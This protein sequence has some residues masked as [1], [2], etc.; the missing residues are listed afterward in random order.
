M[1]YKQV[2]EYQG[3]GSKRSQQLS[4]T[5]ELHH[6]YEKQV[7]QHEN[8]SGRHSDAEKA[9]GI[10]GHPEIGLLKLQYAG[11]RNGKH[12]QEG[13]WQER[14]TEIISDEEKVKGQCPETEKCHACREENQGLEQHCPETQPLLRTD[15]VIPLVVIMQHIEYD[16][17]GEEGGER[18]VET[19]DGIVLRRH[20]DGYQ[21]IDR[22]QQKHRQKRGR[23]IYAHG[24]P[25][26]QDSFLHRFKIADISGTPPSDN[27]SSISRQ[28][29]PHSSS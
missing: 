9:G 22:R 6:H 7:G 3:I 23:E 19:R 16:N 4:H 12:G 10:P 29:S 25:V 21:R 28:S 26:F 1:P 13:V 20:I 17:R 27:Q 11:K 15:L 18:V 5:A 8:Q 14:E 2:N 24:L